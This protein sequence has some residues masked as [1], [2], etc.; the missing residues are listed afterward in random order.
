MSGKD[1]LTLKLIFKDEVVVHSTFNNIH[2]YKYFLTFGPSDARFAG[3]IL[4]QF[5]HTPAG[6]HG[7]EGSFEVRAGFDIWKR[8]R[9]AVKQRHW[10]FHN[11]KEYQLLTNYEHN[12][13]IMKRN[14]HFIFKNL[15]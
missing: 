15:L 7:V 11:R 5:R 14:L 8:K 9:K 2:R 6:G 4:D 3:A 1:P 10:K 12:W 13:I